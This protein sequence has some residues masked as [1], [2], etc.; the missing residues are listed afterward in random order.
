MVDTAALALRLRRGR[1][2][3]FAFAATIL[4][5]HLWEIAGLVMSGQSGYILPSLIRLAFGLALVY[6]IWLGHTWA[7]FVLAAFCE[8]TIYANLHLIQQVPKMYANRDLNALVIVALLTVGYVPI[9]ILA[10]LSH[11]ITSLIAYRRDEREL[12]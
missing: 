1:T 8:W 4:M 5:I 12:G 2:V 3:L 11:R 6:A 9:A 10:V 7:R